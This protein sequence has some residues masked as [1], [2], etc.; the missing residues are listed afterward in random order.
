MHHVDTSMPPCCTSNCSQLQSTNWQKEK[1]QYF[2]LWWPNQGEIFRHAFPLCS[3][4]WTRKSLFYFS[5]SVRSAQHSSVQY[6]WR[7]IN[8]Q[9][10]LPFAY[11]EFARMYD[12][13]HVHATPLTKF[14]RP[15]FF[16]LNWLV[17]NVNAIAMEW[18]ISFHLF[19]RIRCIHTRTHAS[20]NNAASER[21]NRCKSLDRIWDSVHSHFNQ[22]NIKWNCEMAKHFSEV[23]WM[24]FAIYFGA[25]ACP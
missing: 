10:Q 11:H 4:C 9:W 17:G 19:S 1:S 15:I 2:T 25:R 20:I 6:T 24:Q 18:E 21:R 13:Q 23:C 14:T 5:S 12:A 16:L 22:I 8:S 3:F 7:M